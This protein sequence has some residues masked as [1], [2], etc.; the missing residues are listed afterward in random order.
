MTALSTEARE[1]IVDSLSGLGIRVYSYAP[2]VPSP[3][4]VVVIPDSPWIRPTRI[5][6]NLNSEVRWRLLLVSSPRK[7]DAAQLDT[8]NYVDSILDALPPNYLC[9][10]VGQPQLTDTGAQ[11]TVITTEINLSANMKE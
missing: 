9:T 2:P 5:G 1:E 3:P 4:C 6:S 11:G 7:N 10:L 8:E